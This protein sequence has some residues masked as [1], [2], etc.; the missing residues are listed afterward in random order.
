MS[1]GVQEYL[2]KLEQPAATFHVNT[3]MHEL[4][5]THKCPA[6]RFELDVTSDFVDIG[7][8]SDDIHAGEEAKALA[9][10][11]NFGNLHFRVIEKDI[12]SVIKKRGFRYSY[13]FVAPCDMSRVHSD[14]NDIVDH[15]GFTFRNGKMRLDVWNGPEDLIVDITQAEMDRL[16]E[17]GCDLL[18]LAMESASEKY[19][20]SLEKDNGRDGQ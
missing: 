1:K 6:G 5:R 8:S 16:R 3:F 14:G 9:R 17:A 2:E 10:S 13:D 4:C 19:K 20:A 7:K 11:N 18:V 15:S 12:R